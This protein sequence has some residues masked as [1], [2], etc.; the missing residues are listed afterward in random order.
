[1]NARNENLLIGP[2]RPEPPVYLKTLGALEAYV[3]RAQAAWQGAGAGAHQLKRS[4]SLLIARRDQ[5]VR[6]AV[7][8]EVAGSRTRTGAR[9]VISGIKL[10]LHSWGMGAA[11]TLHNLSLTLRQHNSWH[12]D[13]DQLDL[14]LER[15]ERCRLSDDHTGPGR[16]CATP[17]RS[18]EA[19]TCRI[20]MRHQSI[21]SRTRWP[22][23]SCGSAI[24]CK[25][26]HW[27]GSQ[28]ATRRYA[29]AV[30]ALCA[31]PISTRK[32]PRHASLWP[33]SRAAAAI[34]IW[35]SA[36]K[37]QPPSSGDHNELPTTP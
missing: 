22:T 28:P 10:M 13:T 33:K 17:G 6:R 36:T 32:T 3:H 24:P 16:R 18:A 8:I 34:P 7:L 29:Q 27:P 21:R 20:T 19:A 5:P 30:R 2:R 37:V 4:V 11:L 26:W 25:A 12:T 1:M 35:L 14:L 23:G 31:P 9:N 15:A